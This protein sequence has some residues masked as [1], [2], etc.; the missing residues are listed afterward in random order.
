MDIRQFIL[1]AGVGLIHVKVY[2]ESGPDSL[3][4]GALIRK[5]S[6]LNNPFYV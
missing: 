2:T 4:G 5:K 1:P 3:P 6:N